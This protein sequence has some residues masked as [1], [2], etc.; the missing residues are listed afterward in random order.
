MKKSVVRKVLIRV[1][2]CVIV[3]VILGIASGIAYGYLF[4]M[5]AI[6]RVL[7]CELPD[8]GRLVD[9]SYFWNR[10]S[11]TLTFP[12]ERY[13]EIKENLQAKE[14]AC[15]FREINPISVVPLE[16]IYLQDKEIELVE[17]LVGNVPSDNFCGVLCRTPDETI[18]YITQ[19]SYAISE[20][21]RQK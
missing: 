2:C 1:L 9:Y 19:P 18:L 3:A 21:W 12:R 10:L 13:E 8:D 20:K 17:Y 6:I 5:P 15:Y 14:I 7:G 4:K 16:I 11:A